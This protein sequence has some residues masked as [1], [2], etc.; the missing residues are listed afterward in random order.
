MAPNAGAHLALSAKRPVGGVDVHPPDDDCGRGASDGRPFLGQRPARVDGFPGAHRPRKL[1]VDP[2]PLRDRRHRHVHAAEPNRGRDEQ[3]GRGEAAAG[4]PGVDG[5]RGEVAC[6]SGEERD[7][8]FRDGAPPRRPLAAEG[9]V[10][11]RDRLQ[12]GASIARARIR[13]GS[14][15]PAMA[16]PYASRSSPGPRALTYDDFRGGKLWLISRRCF[17]SL[18]CCSCSHWCC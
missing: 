15:E 7:L 16:P 8:R 13:P 4:V 6:H 3:R 10:V 14:P 2:L 18:Q 12:V 5:K 9:K 1:P 17:W 11:E